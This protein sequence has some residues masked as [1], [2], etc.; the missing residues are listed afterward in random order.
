MSV[1][2]NTYCLLF[3]GTI[4][5]YQHR[6]AL[7]CHINTSA[8]NILAHCSTQI[9]VIVVPRDNSD[10]H[11]LY[12][13]QSMDLHTPV[14]VPVERDGEYQVSIF[15]IRE[16][17]GILG[18]GVGYTEHVMVYTPAMESTSSLIPGN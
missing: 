18:S 10:V 8:H 2:C 15:A 1:S 9:Q 3:L 11:K 5:Q 12:I 6:H 14:T 16:G 7:T 17:M 13:N 4:P